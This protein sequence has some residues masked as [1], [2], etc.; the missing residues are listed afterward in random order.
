LPQKVYQN[1]IPLTPDHYTD[2]NLG[3]NLALGFI[4]LIGLAIALAL[5]FLIVVAGI[6]AERIRRK[7]EGYMP[8]PT[9]M[10]DKAS[11]MSRLPPEQLFGTVGHGRSAAVP[12]I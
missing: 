7:R 2:I 12:T 8:A 9:N 10:F 5:I 1:D 11:Q 3:G 4:V 6:L